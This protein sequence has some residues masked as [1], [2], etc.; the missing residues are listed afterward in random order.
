[1][2]RQS[3]ANAWRSITSKL[4][5][6]SPTYSTRQL[7]KCVVNLSYTLENY[8]GTK[9]W[10]FGRWLSFANCW[11]LGSMLI[12]SGVRSFSEHSLVQNHHS[13]KKNTGSL[14]KG[15]HEN[16]SMLGLFNYNQYHLG[17]T[18]KIQRTKHMILHLRPT[19]ENSLIISLEVDQWLE[20]MGSWLMCAAM[21]PTEKTDTKDQRKHKIHAKKH[22]CNNFNRNS[23]ASAEVQWED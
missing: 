9:S 7:L 6:H 15:R 19:L 23:Q 12:L 8:H 21:V 16:Q 18:T 1:M 10:R 5:T 4:Y 3:F 22:P 17:L 11:F 13:F 14:A 20:R 2:E